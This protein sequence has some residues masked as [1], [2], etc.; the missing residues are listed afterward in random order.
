MLEG[1]DVTH[2]NLTLVRLA[3]IAEDDS[4]LLEIVS[5]FQVVLDHHHGVAL[6]DQL[7]QHVEQLGHVVEMQA[8]GRLVENVER[9]AGGAARQFLGELDA[10]RLAARQRGR[11]LANMDIAEADA[12]QRLQLVA[13]R[14]HRLEEVQRIPRP[15]CRARR[16]WICP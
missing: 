16:R 4:T 1:E 9:L 15:S 3:A 2:E 7:V 11:L 10:L 14:R 5:W 6:V 12:L 8:G 13:D